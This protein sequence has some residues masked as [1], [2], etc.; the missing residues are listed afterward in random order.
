[1]EAS[2]CKIVFLFSGQGSHYQG[3]GESLFESNTCFANSMYQ[4]DAFIMQHTGQSLVEELYF[5]KSEVFDDLLVTHPAIVAI[6]V[7]MIEVMKEL[8]VTPHYI[9]G[10]SLGEFAAGV[11]DDIWTSQRALEVSIEQAKSII[12]VCVPGGMIAVMDETKNS[13]IP[14][15]EQFN[16][17]LASE[18]ISNHFTVSGPSI[19]LNAFENQL[20][21]LDISYM[22][23][24]VAYPFHSPSIEP[25]KSEFLYNSYLSSPHAKPSNR[26]IS[27]LYNRALDELPDDYFWKVISHKT[28]LISSVQYMES[29]GPCFYIDLGP[30]GTM[31]TFVKYNLGRESNS[32]ICQIMT[33]YK[34]ELIQ[35]ELLQDLL[36]MDI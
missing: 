6:E 31:A 5:R 16:L 4:S 13:I 30:S 29:L 15:L 20:R 18:N 32:T 33:P 34:K 12:Q 22:R 19:H 14:L 17:H 2:N 27:G 7:A 25:A 10:N 11:A 35:I 3:M 23:L 1:M 9:F 21:R 26:F 28:N 8:G 24:P 36:K